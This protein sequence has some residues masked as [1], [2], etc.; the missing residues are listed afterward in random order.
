[1]AKCEQKP[2]SED[3]AASA[4]A[5]ATAPGKAPI[6]EEE[7]TKLMGAAGTWRTHLLTDDGKVYK[8]IIIES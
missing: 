1:M 4:A 8:D 2:R 6:A 3:V 5:A 7:E